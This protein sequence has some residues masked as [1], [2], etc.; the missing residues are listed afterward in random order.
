M[1]FVGSVCAIS[2]NQ[3]WHSAALWGHGMI[4]HFANILS[5]Q[6]SV[7]FP[8]GGSFLST[9]SVIIFFQNYQ[10]IIDLMGHCKM[11]AAF[12]AILC[13]R[14]GEDLFK[15]SERLDGERRCR[16]ECVNDVAGELHEFITGRTMQDQKFGAQLSDEVSTLRARLKVETSD[17]IQEDEAI[18]HAIN[19]YTRAL[20]EGLRI[21]GSS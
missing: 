14:I 21:V 8:A 20:Q 18:V 5:Q 19:E 15:I 3:C 7:L 2:D 11:L 12:T 10:G 17:R 9:F 1:I 4:H 13:R 6:S 16:E